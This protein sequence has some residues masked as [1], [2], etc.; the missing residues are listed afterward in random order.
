MEFHIWFLPE[1]YWGEE[2]LFSQGIHDVRHHFLLII[3]IKIFSDPS[4]LRQNFNLGSSFGSVSKILAL[5]IKYNKIVEIEVFLKYKCEAVRRADISYSLGAAEI[6][7]SKLKLRS[8][9]KLA[10]HLSDFLIFGLR[11]R[12]Y[13]N[14]DSD[15]PRRF[16]QP[17]KNLRIEWS[18]YHPS[19]RFPG[20]SFMRIVLRPS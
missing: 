9:L 19:L 12:L 6:S 14:F 5:Y 2:A 8:R 18:I 3:R 20:N 17:C 1:K 13:G 11:C 7:N 10:G 16:G 15:I 4:V